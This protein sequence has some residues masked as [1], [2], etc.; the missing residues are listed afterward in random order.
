MWWMRRQRQGWQSSGGDQRGPKEEEVEKAAA[1]MAQ[2]TSRR[3]LSSIVDEK[4]EAATE[5]KPGTK[6]EEAMINIR[7][8]FES[9]FGKNTLFAAKFSLSQKDAFVD[10]YTK[11]GR[12][13]EVCQATHPSSRILDCIEDDCEIHN[14]SF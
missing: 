9:H 4:T 3:S 11:D 1:K 2:R 6:E 13:V 14:I 5:T 7:T 8:Y 12:V 10:Y